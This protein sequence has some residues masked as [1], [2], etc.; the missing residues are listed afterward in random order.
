MPSKIVVHFGAS[1]TG[2]TSIQLTLRKK[3]ADPQFR[4]VDI[5][6]TAS[7]NDEI[8]VAFCEDPQRYQFV[9]R[10]QLT[11]K[12]L[13]ALRARTRALLDAELRRSA[14]RTAIL[15]C[16]A[17][18]GLKDPALSALAEALRKHTADIQAVGYLRSPNELMP[19]AFQQNLKGHDLKELNLERIFPNYRHHV[20]ILDKVFGREQ[21]HCWLFARDALKGG[22]I[23]HDFCQRLGLALGDTLIVRRNDGLSRPAAG[24]LYVY[25]K[26]GPGYGSGVAAIA[27][28]RVL[29]SRLAGLEGPRL[30]FHADLMKP[31]FMRRRENLLWMEERLGVP[32]VDAWQSHGPDAIRSEADLLTISAETWD[33]LRRQLEGAVRTPAEVPRD[34]PDIAAWMHELRRLPPATP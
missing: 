26:F 11:P 33:W 34:P 8:I 2:S 32:M 5:G 1:K 24:L 27:E 19:S 28:N 13:A 4:Y 18:Y 20:T 10:Q 17:I 23:V 7:P 9:R 3:I 16:E 14:G 25:R 12:A 6:K 15:S 29:V 22:S 31:V 21:V 30:W